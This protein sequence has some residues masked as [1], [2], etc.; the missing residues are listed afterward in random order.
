MQIR[1]SED[2]HAP[3]QKYFGYSHF[4]DLQ[5]EIIRNVLDKKDAVVIMPTGGGKSICFQ[6]P[7]LIMEG[8]CI[9]VSPLI[10]LM[11]DQVDGLQANGI[12]ANYVNSS[13]DSIEQQRILDRVFQKELKLLYV[14][15][16]SLGLLSNI[17]N[18]EY[19]SSV[20]I[21]EAHC[22]SSWGHDFRPSYQQLGFLKKTLPNTPIIALTATADKAT[23]QDIAT[24]LS[25]PHAPQFI[26]SFDRK[27]IELDVRPGQDRL[28]QI[29]QFLKENEE[30]SGIVYC[31]SR[32]STEE[33]AEKLKAHGFQAE[34]YHAGLNFEQRN[35]VQEGFIYDKFKIICATVAFG[36]GIDKSNVR[37]VI[38]YN[39]PK[40]IEGYYQEIGRAGRD[41]LESKAILFHSYADVMQLRKFTEGAENEEVQLAKLER[42]QQFSEATSCRRKILL[43]YFGEM[44]SENCGNCDICTKP[45]QFFDGTILAQKVLSTIHRVG[46]KQAIGGIIDVLR[47]AKNAHVLENGLD[48]IKTYGIGRDVSW[49]H[50]QQYIIQMINQGLV[51]LAFHKKNALELTPLSREVLFHSKKVQLTLA[52][53]RVSSSRKEKKPKESKAVEKAMKTGL[54][55]H[56]RTFRAALAKEKGVPAYVIFSDVS[57]KEM[58]EYAPRTEK[59]FLAITGVG[60]H[61][62]AVYGEMFIGEIVKYLNQRGGGKSDTALQTYAL[63]KEGLSLEEIAVRRNLKEPTIISHLCKMYKDGKE[64]DL[65]QF[66]TQE[67]I[68]RVGEAKEKLGAPDKLKTYFD[69]FKEEMAYQNI[70]I[71]LT[72]L[73]RLKS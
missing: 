39:M 62:M 53:D 18:E 11:K 60:A 55:E 5:E 56:L 61:K 13:Q 47:G 9:V 28:K 7:A 31:L 52:I 46:E 38:H 35:A 66:V 45:P 30:E 51:E 68:R 54:F 73:E 33:L 27:N 65:Q 16:E 22:I 20:A 37:F 67:D 42:M 48:Q 40:N 15:P 58:E 1:Q 6:I 44:L 24:Q 12:E 26:S 25:I 49:A 3:L 19:V 71:C 64:V 36:M 8:V 57:L 72:L 10:A 43:S 50:W 2:I 21:D 59:D 29:V 69:F 41:G 34:A 63:F 32:K 4:R 70:R 17:L 23:R 14:A